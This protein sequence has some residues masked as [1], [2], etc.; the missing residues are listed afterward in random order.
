M[1]NKLCLYCIVLYCIV[2]CCVL[3][4]ILWLVVVFFWQR[5]YWNEMFICWSRF[6]YSGSLLVLKLKLKTKKTF[7]IVPF[8][9][10]QYATNYYSQ[11]GFNLSLD[12]TLKTWHRWK[13]KGLNLNLSQ[14]IGINQNNFLGKIRKTIP[15]FHFNFWLEFD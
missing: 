15:F 2:L 1:F 12:L 8:P 13:P 10:K 11:K 6:S 7:T 4:L 14:S 9:R 3:L 5:F